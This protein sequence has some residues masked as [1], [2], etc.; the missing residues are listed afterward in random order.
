MNLGEQICGDWLRHAQRCDFVSFNVR[1]VEQQGEIDVLGVHMRD[2]IVYACE[3]AMHL[4]TGL[5]YTDNVGKLTQKFRRAITYLEANF[6][7]FDKRLMLWSPIVKSS[8][9]G[10]QHD[11]SRDVSRVLETIGQV[12]GVRIV[13]VINEEFQDAL[14]ALRRVS[15][16]ETKEL[17]SPVM[18]MFQVEERLATHLGNRPVRDVARGPARDALTVH[19]GPPR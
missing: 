16:F 2:R 7:D 18:R 3:V 12:P 4:Q 13:A 15:R 6:A 8:R 19:M 17:D 10:A 14:D 11:Q 1:T 5:Q 9:A